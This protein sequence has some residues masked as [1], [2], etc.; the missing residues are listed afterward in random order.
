MDEALLEEGLRLGQLWDVVMYLDLDTERRLCRG[1]F[2]KVRE[3][4][5]ELAKIADLYQY[6]FA[7]ASSEAYTL[8]LLLEQRDLEAAAGGGR[9]LLQRLPR[10]LVPR[11]RAG[12]EGQGARDPR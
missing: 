1:E 12:G 11:H 8:Y 9:T 6:D 4:I 10:G 2:A 5:E 3:R 7:K